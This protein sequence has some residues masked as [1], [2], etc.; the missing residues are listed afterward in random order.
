MWYCFILW[1][2]AGNNALLVRTQSPGVIHCVARP[3]NITGGVSQITEIIEQ[4]MERAECVHATEWRYIYPYLLLQ[5]RYLR[6]SQLSFS[7]GLRVVSRDA[8]RGLMDCK[9]LLGGCKNTIFSHSICWCSRTKTS[10]DLYYTVK[11]KTAVLKASF[12]MFRKFPWT[13]LSHRGW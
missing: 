1:V 3:T 13:S 11:W 4:Q 8:W 2:N 9:S 10:P 7:L 12:T 5:P 6:P